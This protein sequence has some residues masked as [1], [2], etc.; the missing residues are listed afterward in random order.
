VET[1]LYFPYIRVPKSSWFTQVLLYWDQAATIVPDKIQ[2]DP[3]ALDPYTRELYETQL[4]RLFAPEED[5]WQLN[6]ESFE[7]GFLQLLDDATATPVG[8]TR[9]RLHIGKMSVSLFS[10]LEDRGLATYDPGPEQGMWYQVETSTADRY[11]AYLAAVMSGKMPD[12]LPV[13]NRSESIATLGGPERGIEQQLAMLRYTV[14]T[15]A[16]PSPSGPVSPSELRAFKEK[17]AQKLKR[18]KLH[19]DGVLAD[20][21]AANDP[22]LAGVRLKSMMAA[23]E[24]DVATL[25]EQMKK[26]KWPGVTLLGF[27]AV[28]GAA[29]TTAAVIATGGTALAVGLGVGAGITQL[30]GASY[31]T[32]EL[33]RKPRFN[34][35]AP[36]AYAALAS[37]L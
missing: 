17:N 24:D 13:T 11:M 7:Q 27:G 20:I 15:E 22:E 29:L 2:R 8:A 32:A 33:I 23:V 12:T 3:E 31:V 6:H 10:E 16:L 19:L 4:L 30:G 28:V 5:L 37:K 21:A 9:S 35:R 14:I 26:R 36:L 25:Q 18:C 34:P 1:A